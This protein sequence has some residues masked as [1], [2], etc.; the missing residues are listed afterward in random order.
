M[1]HTLSKSAALVQRALERYNL[2]CTV[3][4][5]PE[6]TRTAQEAAHALQC[7]L[8]QIVKSLIFITKETNEPILI[9]ASGSNRVN[10]QHVASII[11]KTITKADA[12]Y[13]RTVTGFAIGG[14]PPLGHKQPLLTFIDNDLLHFDIV[15]AAAGTPHAVFAL[16]PANLLHVTNGTV[17]N[18]T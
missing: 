5:L 8:G 2:P 10:E 3:I 14:I 6:S 4:E 17:I 13:V 11:G 15:W 9:I 1:E 7:Q 16:S 12:D 18:V